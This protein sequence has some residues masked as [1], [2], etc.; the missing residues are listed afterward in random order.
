MELIGSHTQ[1]KISLVIPLEEEEEE[2]NYGERERGV[3]YVRGFYQDGWSLVLYAWKIPVRCGELVLV[4]R[5]NSL[6]CG[7]YFIKTSDTDW[8]NPNYST[9]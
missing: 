6:I 4:C 1:K 5:Y 7:A 8:T 2:E 3:S 9:I